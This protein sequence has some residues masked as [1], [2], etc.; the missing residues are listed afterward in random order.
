MI[1]S[2][3]R[4]H[5]YWQTKSLHVFSTTAKHFIHAAKE[6]EQTKAFGSY[7]SAFGDTN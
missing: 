6:G 1:L 4:T 2:L 5:T 3:Y 7:S